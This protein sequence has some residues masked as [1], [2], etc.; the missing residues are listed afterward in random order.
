M[1]ET[2]RAN[3]A[4]FI[5]RDDM[6]VAWERRESRAFEPATVAFILGALAERGGWLVDAG[7]STGWFAIPAALRG[8]LVAAFE[9]FEAA[10]LRLQEN[11]ALNRALLGMVSVCAVADV[12]GAA[13]FWRNPAVPLTSGGSIAR[14]GCARPVSVRVP[15]VTIDE[16]M[17]GRDVGVIKLDVEGG[18]IAALEGARETLA[19]CRPH[20]AIEANTRAEADAR[21]CWLAAFGGYEVRDADER[22]LL[23]RPL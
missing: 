14:P 9:P 8:H 13:T 16:A 19:R 18:E 10:R 22:N 7:A 20:L 3:G 17:A 5:V 6:I 12:S 23:C 1:T 15:T 21:R 4:A 2:H 11:A